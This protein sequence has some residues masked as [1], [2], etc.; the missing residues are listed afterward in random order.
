MSSSLARK[1]LYNEKLYLEKKLQTGVHERSKRELTPE[2]VTKATARVE[3]IT[4]TLQNTPTNEHVTEEADRTVQQISTHMDGHMQELRK[5][6]AEMRQLM[7]DMHPQKKARVDK[8]RVEKPTMTKAQLKGKLR[9]AKALLLKLESEKTSA[10]T[11][12]DMINSME[13][14]DLS[15]MSAHMLR[16]LPLKGNWPSL[17][18]LAEQAKAKVESVK[19]KAM[20]A[21]ALKSIE[22]LDEELEK[23]E[24]A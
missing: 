6:L 21:K 8:P 24:G 20:H 14:M 15:T 19:F 3:E 1:T 11:Y 7:T 16:C 23:M 2:E 13:G 17:K 4:Q 5:E 12:Q 9:D 18:R 22:Q 10:V